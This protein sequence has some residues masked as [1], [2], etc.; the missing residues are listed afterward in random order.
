[1]TDLAS[2]P[3]SEQDI[4]LFNEGSHFRLWEKLGS[5][6]TPE[7]VHFAV[8][9][10][11]AQSVAVIGD[12]NGWNPEADP[13]WERGTSGIWEGRV[14]GAALGSVYKYHLVRRGGGWVGDKADPFALHGE[15]PPRTGSVVCAPTHRWA[16]QDWMDGRSAIGVA[17]RPW[18]IYE[19][20]LGSWRR[21]ADDNRWLGY[22][23]IAPLLADHATALGFTHVELMPVMEHPYFG[24]WGYQVT[25][26]FAPSSR[27]G[28]PDDLMY[29]V[30]H[31]HQKGLGVILDWVPS[32]FATDAHGLGY[33][34]G[35]HLFEHA[36]PRRGSH[37]DWGSHIFNYGR[38]EVR[39]FLISSAM[40]WLQCY[41]ADGLRVDGVASMLYLDYSRKPGEW[42]PNQFGGR[43]NLDAIQL[44]RRLNDEVAANLPGVPTIAEESTS[45]P[46]VSRPAYVG[47]LGFGM[48]WDLG[49][50]HDTLDYLAHDPIHRKY[51]HRQL[52]FRSVYASS[53]NF[54]LPLSHDEVVHGKGSWLDKMPGDRWQ[55]FANL[56]LLLGLMYSNPG[57]KLVFMGL[58][59]AQSREWAHEEQLDWQLQDD[60]LHAGMA[61]W[62]TD[63]NRLYRADP[64]LHAGD[65]D[66]GSF[67]WVDADDAL[68]SVISFTRLGGGREILVV[69]NLTPVPRRP[70]RV[71]V[72]R[73]GAWRELLNSDS[74][75]Y[76]G[77]GVGNW[78]AVE[79]T[80]EP[81]HGQ[82]WSLNLSLPPLGL[83]A[84]SDFPEL[85]RE[86]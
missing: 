67:R 45:W 62:V 25:G 31:L 85:G 4:F 21:G 46:M 22:R 2:S 71:G 18:S 72:P 23:E 49:W 11:N 12:F 13:L 79:A 1:M 47:G 82:Q 53:E 30:D 35:T 20:H 37:P 57:K 66:A 70:Y 74:A 5:H 41:H 3:I 26:F 29:L 56:R 68:Q 65:F 28:G 64:A 78:G 27:F 6:P 48:K 54:V 14:A 33:F 80:P 76:G 7:G 40:Y 32:H 44:L 9:A 55:K 42:V 77:S 63:L 38:H 52:T 60:P 69:V 43:E 51:Y 15:I 34:D 83:V 17:Q 19:V 81:W 59:T 75:F 36:D 86:R 73:P 39:A 10:P 16:D 50:M 8:W 24:S 84:L 61:R 58:E